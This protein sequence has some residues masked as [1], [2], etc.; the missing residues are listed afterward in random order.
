MINILLSFLYFASLVILP[1][2]G[3]LSI[4]AVVQEELQCEQQR[5]KTTVDVP[6]WRG[7]IFYPLWISLIQMLYSHDVTLKKSWG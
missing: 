4:T 5:E 6:N 3:L 2:F 7:R 1:Y